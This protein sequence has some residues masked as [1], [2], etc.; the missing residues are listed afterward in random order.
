M[1]CF[2]SII[3]IAVHL[4]VSSSFSSPEIQFDTKT[5]DCG[6]VKEG[7]TDKLSAVFIVT[8]TGDS[9]LKLERVRPSCG[10]TVVKYDSLV[11]P[12]KSVKIESKVRIK[13]YRPG[14]LSKSITVTSNAKNEP[15]VR[16]KINAEIKA[17]IGISRQYV[18]LSVS[19]SVASD[20]IFLTSMK[21]DLKVSDVTFTSNEKKGAAAWEENY[22]TDI[23]FKFSSMDSLSS[24]SS[25]VFRLELFAPEASNASSGRFTIS[26]NHSDKKEIVLTGKI[27]M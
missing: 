18:E 19:D 13:G 15:V 11:Q 23:K 20:T 7:K 3:F 5:F 16:L 17:I 6:T 1:R 14:S 10:C 8:N 26:T 4:V 22:K 24:D 27:A 9:V 2:S 21:K 12:G 25:N